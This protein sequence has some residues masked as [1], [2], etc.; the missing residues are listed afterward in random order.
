MYGPSN[1]E[2]K[3]ESCENLFFPIPFNYMYCWHYFLCDI[4]FKMASSFVITCN[5]AT[6][7]VNNKNWRM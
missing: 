1:L 7:L 6:P 5:F 4:K 3:K 2:L